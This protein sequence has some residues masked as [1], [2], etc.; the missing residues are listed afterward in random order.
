MATADDDLS[1]G[2]RIALQDAFSAVADRVASRF[3]ALHR[4]ISGGAS[5]ITSLLSAMTGGLGGLGRY[6]LGGGIIAGIGALTR[7]SVGAASALENAAPRV[8][9]APREL[10]GS[11]L[12]PR[13][14]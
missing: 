9:H 6:L 14:L 11:E 13:G 10:A 3:N 2:G 8:H 1:F 4:T 7:A 5:K 12:S